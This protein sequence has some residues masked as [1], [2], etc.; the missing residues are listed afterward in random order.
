MKHRHFR[1]IACI[2]LALSLLCTGISAADMHLMAA[3]DLL[4]SCYFETDPAKEGWVFLDRDSDGYGWTWDNGTKDKY[5]V[6][7]GKGIL[8]SRSYENR[9]GALTPDNWAILPAQ[10]IPDSGAQLS[11]YACAQ[12]KDYAGEQFSV[13]AGFSPDPASMF[14]VSADVRVTASYK[15]YTADLSAFA[16]RKVYIAICHAGVTNQYQ[17]NIDK[18]ELTALHNTPRDLFRK[19][20]YFE[21]DPAAEGWTFIDHDGDSHGWSWDDST[22][23]KFSVFEGK[24]ILYSR[25]YENLVGAL[26]P[27]NWAVSPAIELPDKKLELSLYAAGQDSDFAGEV[28]ALY[29]GTRADVSSM[30]KL[31]GD[32]TATANYKRYSADLSDFRGQT[33]YVAIRH[34]NV[35]DKYQLN[36]DAVEILE[37]ADDCGGIFGL[38]PSVEFGDAPKYGNWAHAGIDYCIERGLMNGVSTGVFRPQ[39]TVTRAQLVTILY[40]VAGSP[41]ATF[42][43]TFNDVKSGRF[44]SSAVEWAAEKGIVTGKTATTFDPDG[45]ITREQIAAILYR[46]TGSPE[47]SGSL[48]TF[49]DSAKVSSYA[50]NAL[51]WATKEGLITGV[52]SGDTTTLSPRANATRAQ[53]AAIIM[54]YL[55]K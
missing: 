15:Q 25:S 52:K 30:V 4:Y 37:D 53:I 1:A 36:I 40:R 49:P 44:Y 34:Y 3:S 48:D 21:T 5:Q 43:G 32:F 45:A 7:E 2:V 9:H 18:V 16:G 47:V 33:V 39:G 26:T 55:E 41:E 29:A 10:Q 14:C 51:L 54:R 38:C 19:G 22:G 23:N 6:Y 11:L 28:F 35:S 8:Y 17:L 42:K 46:Y 31:G 12:D 20:F 27:D 24:G 13:Y 50:V